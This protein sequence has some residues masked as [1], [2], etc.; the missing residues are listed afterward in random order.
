MNDS[1]L[2]KKKLLEIE[3]CSLQLETE[4]TISLIDSSGSVISI[5]EG[6]YQ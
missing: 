5:M 1:L 4:K 2:H 6:R 3:K